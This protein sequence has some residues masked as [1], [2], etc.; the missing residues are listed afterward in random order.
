LMR[1][2][3]ILGLAILLERWNLAKIKMIR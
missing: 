2:R 3:Y 1:L